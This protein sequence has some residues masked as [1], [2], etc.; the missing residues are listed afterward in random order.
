ME[1]LYRVTYNGIGIY[2]A[3]KSELWKVDNSPSLWNELKITK[4]FTWLDKPDLYES[5]YRSYFTE[6]GIYNFKNLSLPI[7]L[8]YLDNDLI[9]IQKI[10]KDE[11]SKIVYKDENQIIIKTV[12]NL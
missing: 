1:Y 3:F 11:N 8:K 5:D 12:D 2:E 4:N 10:A 7:M 9:T 6:K